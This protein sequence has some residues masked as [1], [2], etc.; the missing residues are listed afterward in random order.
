LTAEV[1]TLD[2]ALIVARRRPHDNL[3]AE[4]YRVPNA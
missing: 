3:A 4:I 1:R 2:G